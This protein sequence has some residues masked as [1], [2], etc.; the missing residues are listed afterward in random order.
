MGSVW[1]RKGER[2]KREEDGD[3]PINPL[4]KIPECRASMWHPLP[5]SA[6]AHNRH[7]GLIVEKSAK[8][9]K[10]HLARALAAGVTEKSTKINSASIAH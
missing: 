5:P 6:D 9:P 2:G 8:D 4:H 7:A 1:T 10:L 3:I